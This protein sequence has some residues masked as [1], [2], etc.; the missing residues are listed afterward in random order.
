MIGEPQAESDIDYADKWQNAQDRMGF[1]R[2]VYCILF[3]QLL[4]TSHICLIPF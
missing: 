4:F 3:S 1:I 2:K